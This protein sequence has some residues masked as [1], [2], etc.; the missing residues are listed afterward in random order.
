MIKSS[1]KQKRHKSYCIVIVT[2]LLVS[3]LT[4]Y[5]HTEVP[6]LTSSLVRSLLWS[7]DFKHSLVYCLCDANQW[8]PGE[9]SSPGV[10]TYYFVSGLLKSS[11]FLVRTVWVL[12]VSE[13][14]STDTWMVFF[15]CFHFEV[16]TVWKCLRLEKIRLCGTCFSLC[17]GD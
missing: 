4:L 12:I 10:H 15:P 9:Q 14:C 8:L 13:S 3:V 17:C 5:C 11:T 1:C 7:P 6:S 2:S 16:K